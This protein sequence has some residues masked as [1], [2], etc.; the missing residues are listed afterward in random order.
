MTTTKTTGA[1]KTLLPPNT[2][3][4]EAFGPPPT[5][6]LLAPETTHIEN[7]PPRRQQQF[8]AARILARTALTHLGHPAHPLLPGP[9]GAPQ[10]P[11][12]TTGSITHC[13]G[14]TACAAAPT[15][16]H[17]SLGID[18]EPTEPLPRG[19]L[20]LT[21]TATEHRQLARL[22]HGVIPWDRLLFSAKE[23]TY[24][25]FY[26]LTRTWTALASITVTLHPDGTF[27]AR[28]PLNPQPHTGHW[29][30]HRG[31]LITALT[32]PPH[33]RQH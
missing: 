14:Y 7:R 8:T 1:L 5:G 13:D 28:H 15:T 26:P 31:I 18:A 24:K 3:T 16:H 25:A 33:T 22:P 23:A 20:H 12:G 30:T 32:L 21:A 11:N 6:K 10:W 19:T 29:T 9:G 17:A 4:A 27:T 2:P